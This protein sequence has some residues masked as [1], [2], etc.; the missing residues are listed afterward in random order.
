MASP[1][2]QVCASGE[3]AALKPALAGHGRYEGLA[4]SELPKPLVN[5]TAV[6]GSLCLAPEIVRANDRI[7]SR[8][9]R[10]LAALNHQEFR[11]LEQV[12]PKE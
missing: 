11:P 9:P 1:E 7:R 2:S 3:S 4:A 5:M 6:V 12:I 10:P 8:S